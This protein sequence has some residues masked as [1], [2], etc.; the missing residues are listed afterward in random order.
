MNRVHP[1]RNQDSSTPPYPQEA[2]LIDAIPQ[3]SADR[4]LCTSAGLAQFAVEV[5]RT[6]PHAVVC[7]TYL[8]LYRATLRGT[9]GPNSRPTCES[10]ALPTCPRRKPTWSHFHSRPAAKRNSLAI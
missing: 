7:C 8:D 2:I 4:L 6:L 5:A 1:N 3:M 9:I 10:I